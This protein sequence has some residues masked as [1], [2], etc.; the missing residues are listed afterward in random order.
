VTWPP[1]TPDVGLVTVRIDVCTLCLSGAGG[2]CHVPGCMFWM[3]QAPDREQVVRLRLTLG[4]NEYAAVN[5]GPG[6][7]G[8]GV[9]EDAGAQMPPPGPDQGAP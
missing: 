5:S 8:E 4:L 7:P 3:C 6:G 1:G 9:G 2:E